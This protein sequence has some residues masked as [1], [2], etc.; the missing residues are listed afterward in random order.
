[1][2][3]YIIFL[4]IFF[5]HLFSYAQ[6]FNSSL[7]REEKTFF[8]ENGFIWIKD[9][10]SDEQVAL[11]KKWAE[12]IDLTSRHILR[13]QESS[14]WSLSDMIQ[15]I[16]GFVIVVPE[17]GNSQKVCR[18]ED[19]YTCVPGLYDLIQGSVISY[20]DRLL[21]EPYVLFKEK[22]NFKHPGG[23]A[24]LPHQDF[25]AYEFLGPRE[26]VTAMVTIDA[27]TEEN[28]CLKMALDWKETFKDHP[29]V[30]KDALEK[31]KFIFPYIV[32]GKEHG[33]I[34]PEFSD[35]IKWLSLHTSPKDLVLFSSYIPH[36]SEVN[37]SQ[38][39]RRSM[40][41]TLNKLVEGSHRSAYYYAKRKDP[42][43]PI[44]HIGTPTKATNK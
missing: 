10:F 44:F 29:A 14:G 30:D 21:G 9:F 3:R 35:Q 36:Y 6:D 33:A 41:F 7:G 26:H 5:G 1:M 43:N 13:V 42:N 22:I 16:P 11:I 18:A 39:P 38:G 28:G 2:Q 12:D 19:F 34:Q 17:A 32:G 4:V 20:V 31:G 15:K 27:A 23:G 8:E 25:P 24:F 37:Q 40:F